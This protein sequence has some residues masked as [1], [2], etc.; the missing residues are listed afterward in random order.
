M[1]QVKY[2]LNQVIQ[3]LC[4]PW[5]GSSWEFMQLNMGRGGVALKYSGTIEVCFPVLKVQD[6]GVERFMR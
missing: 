1:L 6:F 4:S 5:W 2:L 3:T